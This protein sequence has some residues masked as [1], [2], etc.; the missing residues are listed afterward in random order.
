MKAFL[1]IILFSILA[2]TAVPSS[3]ENSNRVVAFVNDDV[4]T[5]H[6]LNNKIIELTGKT[7]EELRS[8]SGEDF[9]KIRE[10]ILDLIIDEKIIKAKI[11]ELGMEVTKNEVDEYIE[12]RK[13]MM[14]MTQED[15]IK[16]LESEGMSYESF[17]N[18]MKLDL[19]RSN[20]IDSEIRSKLIITEDDMLDYYNQHREDYLKE[21]TVHIASIFLTSDAVTADIESLKQKGKEILERLKKGEKFEVLAK[22]FSNGPGAEDGGDLGSIPVSQIDPRIYAVI[23]DMDQGDVSD[24][25]I[26]GNSIQI[27]K[28]IEKIEGRLVPFEKVKEEIYQ[29]MYN[30]EIEK[31]YRSWTEDLR[32]G[33]YIKKIL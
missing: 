4:I 14:K 8:E 32:D 31:K 22:E 18:S 29:S 7:S 13:K 15:L 19:E 23:K 21:A 9:F 3:A 33:F 10:D 5:L 30:E 6:E 1:T 26:R 20:L 28:L 11:V 27:I 2:A 16:K 17:Y 25:V 12:Y 24:L